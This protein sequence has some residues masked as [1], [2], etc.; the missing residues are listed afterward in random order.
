MGKSHVVFL[1][2]ALHPHLQ[3]GRERVHHRHADAMQATRKPVVLQRKFAASVQPRQ[4]HFNTRHLLL[5]M[6]VDRHAAAIVFHGQ[7][8]ILV[9][10]HLNVPSIASDGLI[11]AVIK[12]FLGHMVGPR[13]VGK[14]ARALAHR[15][16]AAQDFNSR[17]VIDVAH[18]RGS[19]L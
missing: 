19:L 9:Q 5:R 4:D 10:R 7:R 3:T 1:A 12:H 17:G 11:H 18:G 14:H 16:Q 13:G 8:A 15:F 2:S 6:E